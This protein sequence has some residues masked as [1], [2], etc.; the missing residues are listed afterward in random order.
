MPHTFAAGRLTEKPT[1]VNQLNVAWKNL[2]LNI[3][4]RCQ[5]LEAENTR[6]LSDLFF[7]KKAFLLLKQNNKIAEPLKPISHAINF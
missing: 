1:Q 4:L 5:I 3:R 6:L 2:T 7:V